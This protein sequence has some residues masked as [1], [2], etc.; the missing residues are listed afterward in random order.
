M[1][2][3]PL[4]AADYGDGQHRAEI[5]P[6]PMSVRRERD[7]RPASL[8][9][10]RAYPLV[11]DCA[12]TGCALTIRIDHSLGDWSHVDVDVPAPRAET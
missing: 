12:A 2:T 5:R 11:A 8:L 9:D 7:G 10:P 4:A 3:N 1:T 6:E